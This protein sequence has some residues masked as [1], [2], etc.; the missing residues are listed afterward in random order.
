[1]INSSTA[2]D[3]TGTGLTSGTN[4]LQLNTIASPDG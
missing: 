2:A 4:F 3:L 1:M